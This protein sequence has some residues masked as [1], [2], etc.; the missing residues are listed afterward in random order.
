[1]RYIIKLYSKC[2]DILGV[3]TFENKTETF[4]HIEETIRRSKVPLEIKT[5]KL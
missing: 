4:L 2:Y 5:E 1:M 3:V